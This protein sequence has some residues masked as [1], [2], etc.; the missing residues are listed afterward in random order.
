MKIDKEALTFDKHVK[1]LFNICGVEGRRL[2][3]IKVVYLGVLLYF[4][5]RHITL[6]LGQ[7]TFVSHEKYAHSRRSFLL[8]LLDPIINIH[9]GVVFSNI[10]NN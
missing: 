5:D 8:Q 1:C 4:R 2:N 3:I 6:L 7:I 9:E 10:I